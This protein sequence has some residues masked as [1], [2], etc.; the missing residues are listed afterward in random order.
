MPNPI[1]FL[2]LAIW[3]VVTWQ[4]Y[5][6]LD[7]QRAL[8]WTI[9]AG[10][11]LLPPLVKFDLPVIPDLD[12]N[13]IPGLMAALCIVLMLGE[14][15]SLLPENPFGKALVGLYVLGPFLT[16]LTNTD[17]LIFRLTEIGGMKIYD[18]F[19][20][21][22]NQLIWL[23][24]L[25][26]GRKY[27]G[28]PEGMRLLMGAMIAGGL[29]YSIPMLIEARVSPQMNIWVYGF[30]QH[31]FFQTIRAGGYRPVVFLPHGLWVAFYTLM[32]LMSALI[33]LRVSPAE[34]RPKALA[35]AL[36]MAF[37]L[38]VCKS[39]GVLAYAALFCPLLLLAT[40]RLMLVVAGMVAAVVVAYPLLRGLHV[41]PLDAILDFA[42]GFSTERAGSL[43]FRFENE[44]ILLARAEERPWFGWGGFGRNFTHDPDTGEML[45]IADGAWIIVLG[46]YGWCGYIADFGLT[47]LPLF[48]LM[49]EALLA[50]RGEVSVVTGGMGLILGA[51]MLDLLPNATQVP[52][53]WLVAGALLG[54][55][56]RLRHLRTARQADARRAGLHGGRARRTVI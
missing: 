16:V 55:A 32:C 8:I 47:A 54:E 49:R 24:P 2:M 18:S 35:I 29:A 40:P 39:A 56:E 6:K 5:R 34:Q 12:K 45:N 43:R 3:P 38:V 28:N 44:E 21:M 52:L 17:P 51:S 10:Y 1:A 19:A 25:F 7:P 26:L 48:L 37:M 31:D 41:V 11:L 4:M 30:F 23:L 14:R 53:T 15:I 27:L 50:R 36:Y 13:T 46:I 42:N 22:A 33:V 9:L 20:A